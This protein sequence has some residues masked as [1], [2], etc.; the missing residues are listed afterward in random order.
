MSLQETRGDSHVLL[1]NDAGGPTAA[2]DL[3][4]ERF[5]DSLPGATTTALGE[6]AANFFDE[7]A[8]GSLAYAE[9]MVGLHPDV[10]VDVAANDAV[11]A[12]TAFVARVLPARQ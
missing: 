5:A 2:A 11:A 3:V 9:T 4:V 8:Q 12:V 10:D 7:A 6:L 1:H